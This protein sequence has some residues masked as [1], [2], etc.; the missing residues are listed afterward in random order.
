MI[1]FLALS[2]II[3][4]I[5]ACYSGDSELPPS[6]L[7]CW[8]GTYVFE[9]IIIEEFFGDIWDREHIYRYKITIYEENGDFFADIYVVMYHGTRYHRHSGNVSTKVSGNEEWISLTVLYSDSILG[10]G[11]H[12]DSVAISFRRKDDNI[13][14]YWGRLNPAIEEN[15]ESGRIFFEKVNDVEIYTSK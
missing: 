11:N 9:E 13:Y 7:Y 14:T 2:A 15:R 8:V 6:T 3:L 4:T 10:S 12:R 5:A 1:I